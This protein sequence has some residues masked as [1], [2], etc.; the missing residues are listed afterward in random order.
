MPRKDK[1]VKKSGKRVAVPD[2]QAKVRRA[3]IEQQ[4]Q[5]IEA[6]LRALDKHQATIDVRR[7]RLEARKV[8]FEAELGDNKK[9][10]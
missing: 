7:A 4:V 10:K 1:T 9:T 5:A 6:G 8:A 3:A 2:W